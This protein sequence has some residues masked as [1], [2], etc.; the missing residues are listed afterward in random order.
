MKQT[1]S[2]IKMFLG[3]VVVLTFASCGGSTNNTGMPGG[4]TGTGR[5]IYYPVHD[6]NM[7]NHDPGIFDY[8]PSQDLG[9]DVQNTNNDNGVGGQDIS[10]TDPGAT[11]TDVHIQDMHMDSGA[12]HDTGTRDTNIGHDTNGGHDAGCTHNGV[13]PVPSNP[14][15]C[16]K[17]MKCGCGFPKCPSGY[18]CGYTGY[19]ENQN[20]VC[21]GCMSGKVC[22]ATT[23]KCEDDPAK[24]STNTYCSSKFGPD[25]YCGPNWLCI[26]K[27]PCKTDADCYR[28]PEGQKCDKT[29]GKCYSCSDSSE[30][31]WDEACVDG[32]CQ[33]KAAPC[34]KVDYDHLGTPDDVEKTTFI[35]RMIDSKAK[36]YAQAFPDCKSNPNGI[37]TNFVAMNGA[38]FIS[39]GAGFFSA[40]FSNYKS[41]PGTLFIGFKGKTGF[42]K[43]PLSG[44]STQSRIVLVLKQKYRTSPL[45]IYVIARE[46]DGTW[47]QLS[48]RGLKILEAG[49]GPLQVS[50]LWTTPT[51]VDLHLEEPSGDDIYYGCGGI[52]WHPQPNQPA[53]KTPSGGTLDIDSNA[54]CGIDNI[55]NENI[56]YGGTPPVGH[57]IIRVDY[58]DNCDV[59]G[60]T[61]FIV[62]LW[63]A[64]HLQAWSGSFDANDADSGG[65]HSGRI[66][67]QFDWP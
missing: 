61:D 1:R 46:A 26:Q 29:T 22:N 63:K 6:I 58:W 53:C 52:N 12:T 64:G 25:F 40:H 60:P 15:D 10:G 55:N 38:S 59:S 18:E 65:A 27:Y 50:V 9:R 32:Q 11:N 24:C 2:A 36:F 49:G 17:S 67:H 56:F 4:D 19:C 23:G 66:I 34:N 54:A 14:K 21:T 8:A 33:K 13:Y 47:G 7:G 45:T 62:T 57:Y 44:S 16:S 28:R 31:A 3:C 41:K 20:C 30:C 5:D 48:Y 51:D 43:V 37:K 39:G 42:W 35:L